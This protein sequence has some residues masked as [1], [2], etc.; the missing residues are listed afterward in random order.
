MRERA[1][2][3]SDRLPGAGVARVAHHAMQRGLRDLPAELSMKGNA[4][5][6]IDADGHVTETQDQVVKYLDD[7]YRRRPTTMFFYPWDGWDRRMLGTLGEFAGT[8]DAWLKALDRGGMELAVLYPTLGSSCRSSRIGNGRWRSA[9]PTTR[10]CTRSSRRR[11]R[12]SRR[13][14]FYRSR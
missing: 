7:P 1:P 10:S 12:A 2:L 8:S 14:A 5:N 13:W 9:A 6:V 11:R 3:L 4:M